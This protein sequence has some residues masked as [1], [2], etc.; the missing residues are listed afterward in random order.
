M[1][2]SAIPAFVPLSSYWTPQL[3]VGEAR[4]LLNELD[5]ERI[6]NS[7][8]RSHINLCIG[9]IAEML[10]MSQEP[11]YEIIWQVALES[12]NHFTGVPWINLETPVA[13]TAASANTGQRT[14]Q[15]TPGVTA[16]SIVPS[17][18]IR[19]VTLM[20]ASKSAAQISGNV[21]NVWRGNLTRMSANEL[22]EQGNK[23]YN[24]QYRQSLGWCQSGSKIMIFQGSEIAASGTEFV[25][26]G[27]LSLFGHRKPLLDNMFGEYTTGTGFTQLIDLPD[28]HM[29]L[30]TVMV[31]KMTLQQVQKQVPAEMDNEVTQ[32]MMAINKQA[33]EEYQFEAMKRTKIDQALGTR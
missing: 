10:N 6:Q 12:S 7:N 20:I 18:L 23:Q 9:H 8:I 1:P 11:W 27:Q 29:R 2:V 28:Q 25:F 26:P 24:T 14:P 32:L 17:N 5:N 16:G 21:A 3:I 33:A 15:Q 30:L 22:M 4:V 19:K 13:W 31:Q